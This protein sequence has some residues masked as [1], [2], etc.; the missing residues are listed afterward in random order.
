MNETQKKLD[1]KVDLKRGK[2]R[3]DFTDINSKLTDLNNAF[4]SSLASAAFDSVLIAGGSA[5]A[6]AAA[7]AGFC[8]TYPELIRMKLRNDSRYQNKRVVDLSNSGQE[9]QA[10]AETI[11]AQFDAYPDVACADR[12]A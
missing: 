8:Q 10:I 12:N 3:A 6:G 7:S 5:T 9:A 4:L 2:K 1:F 11:G